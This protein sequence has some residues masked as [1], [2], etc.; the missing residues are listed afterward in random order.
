MIS[1]TP[2]QLANLAKIDSPTVANVIELFNVGSY[3]D[4]FTDHTIKAIYPELS[5]IVGYAAT[6][7]Y[8][9]SEPAQRE[10][11][12]GGLPQLIEE[13]MSVKEPRIIVFQD[14][15]GVPRAATYGEVM[16][17]SFQSF[18]FV[19]LISSGAARDIEQ[20]GRLRFPCWAS[21]TIVSHGYCRFIS[22]QIPVKVG[23]LHVH[24]GDLLHADANGI[25]KIPHSIASAVAD[26]CEPFIQAEQIVLDYLQLGKP[27]LAGYREAFAKF[28]TSVGELRLRAHEFLEKSERQ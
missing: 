20:V 26:L 6:A 17:K 4:G 28:K 3:L 22:A 19:G 9:A 12:Y 1:L 10:E 11:A 8:R 14:L 13:I 18:G 27:T 24:P 2:Q 21:S 25:I 15:D 7:T 16:A 23:G 5:P